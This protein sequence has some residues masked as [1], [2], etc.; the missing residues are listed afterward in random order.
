MESGRRELTVRY[1]I[2]EEQ[3]QKLCRITEFEKERGIES[4]PET[5]FDVIMAA[6]SRWDIDEKLQYAEQSLE[7]ARRGIALLKIAESI[8]GI[9]QK[10]GGDET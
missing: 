5:W 8:A 7:A 3:Y 10:G 6:G 9:N 2:T 1:H 4:T